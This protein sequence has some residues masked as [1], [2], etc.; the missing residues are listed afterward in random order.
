[1]MRLKKEI[2][3]EVLNTTHAKCN[4]DRFYIQSCKWSL[5]Y[6]QLKDENN[7]YE[8][9]IIKKLVHRTRI[10]FAKELVYVEYIPF[11]ID[12][13]R[14]FYI[15]ELE[16]MEF[17]EFILFDKN[18]KDIT[19]FAPRMI[20]LPGDFDGDR[21]DIVK[22]PKFTLKDFYEHDRNRTYAINKKVSIITKIKKFLRRFI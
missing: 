3:E 2:L 15:D 19:I 11:S 12:G 17:I 10:P 6:V 14:Y 22:A 13:Y 21:I 5:M 20:L 18:M 16:K 9:F 4:I 7:K 1:M 8:S